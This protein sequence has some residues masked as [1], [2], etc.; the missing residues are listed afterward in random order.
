MGQRT[1]LPIAPA[2]TSAVTRVNLLLKGRPLMAVYKNTSSSYRLWPAITN[3][4]TGTTLELQPG[5]EVDI[6]LPNEFKDP[7][8]RPAD[9]ADQPAGEPQSFATGGVVS[10]PADV[11]LQEGEQVVSM[12]DDLP[13]PPVPDATIV[14]PVDK[15]LP[16]PNEPDPNHEPSP[17]GEHEEA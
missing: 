13:A 9:E 17:D 8:L 5:E 6:D 2:R 12:T 11:Q 4:H 15:T 1:R 3:P 10:A 7:H 14:G 16:D